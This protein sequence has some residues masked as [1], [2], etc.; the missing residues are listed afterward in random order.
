MPVLS[1]PIKIVCWI[2]FIIFLLLL[3]KNILFKKSPRYYKNYFRREYQHY[4]TEDG[5]AKANT[6]PFSTITLFYNSRQLNPEYKKNNLLGNLFGF[7]PFGFLVPVLLPWFRHGF[8]IL[9]AGFL[10]SLGYEATQLW[11]GLGIFD[12]DDLILNTAGSF[13]GYTIFFITGLITRTRKN[14]LATV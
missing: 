7:V 14:R 2:L 8:K 3:T 6:R 10:L 4:K 9:L 1:H 11:L 5:W 13:I 12:V